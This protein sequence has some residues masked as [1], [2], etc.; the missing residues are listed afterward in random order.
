MMARVISVGL[1]PGRRNMIPPHRPDPSRSPQPPPSGR[2]AHGPRMRQRDTVL[3]RARRLTAW[4]A[5]GGL[6][7]TGGLAVLAER[8]FSGVRPTPVADPTA[9]EPVVDTAPAALTLPPLPAPVTAAPVTAAPI[10][11]APAAQV[12]PQ[13][14]AAQPVATAPPPTA[15]RAT[16]APP[17]VPPTAAPIH[18]T[19]TTVKPRTHHPQ[20]VVVVSGGS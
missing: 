7:M 8:A 13:A 19:P 1:H 2:P 17:T 5:A 6:V 12:A 4:T 11:I 10:A 3:R 16:I 9:T 14:T 15:A 18:V 20:P